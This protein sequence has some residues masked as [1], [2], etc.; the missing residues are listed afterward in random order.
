MPLRIK[1]LKVNKAVAGAALLLMTLAAAPA[2]ADV[3]A[4]VEAWSRGDYGAAVGE[5]QPLA[6]AGDPDAMFNLAQAYRLGR[7]VAAN[8]P[9][10]EALY[11]KAAAAGHIQAADTYGLM[12][13]QDGRR[14]AALPYVQDAAR[15]GDPRSQYLLGVAHFNGDLV[16][17]D[18][19]RAYALVSLAN[20]EGL[21]QAAQALA[22]MDQNIPLAQRQQGA[23]L[24]QHLKQ[25]AEATR[26]RELAAVQLGVPSTAAPIA[27]PTQ[28]PRAV[29]AASPRSPATTAVSPSIAAAR[30]AV[31]AASRATGTESP[32]TA[33]ASFARP[34]P[35]GRPAAVASNS[36]ATGPAQATRPEPAPARRA[37][38]A[39]TTAAAASS[40]D[41]RVQLGAFSVAGNAQR[42]WERLSERTELAGK[43]RLMVPAGRVTKL[44]AGG[45]ASR[46]AAD[47]ACRS[48][49][50]VGHDCLVTQG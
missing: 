45:Y 34:A 31:A 8:L 12:L 46:A 33:G 43:E 2:L 6:D 30:A 20:S 4:G 5:W 42:L 10:A 17:R 47:A 40:G 23:G 28:A 24:A 37:P 7:G 3:K 25:E 14:E 13:F 44:Q 21:P 49:R 16:S 27:A 18:W 50:R 48:L 29:V 15:R 41:W 11:A 32:A 38:A 1:P 22:Q 26:A 19:V 39:A 36:P 35:A 9:R